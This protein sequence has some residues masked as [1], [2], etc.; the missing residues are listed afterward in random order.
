MCHQTMKTM[1]A[2][3]TRIAVRTSA[4]RQEMPRSYP[5]TS[6]MLSSLTAQMTYNGESANSL[7]DYH[8]SVEL[9]LG[10]H[11]PPFFPTPLCRIY[12]FP[13]LCRCPTSSIS[14]LFDSRCFRSPFYE[15]RP[16]VQMKRQLVNYSML[17]KLARKYSQT[18]LA[19]NESH[20]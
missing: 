17:T 8:S 5:P 16:L 13:C 6:N 11:Y 18:S 15:K 14:F 12:C 7:L 19:G 1:I 3:F 4:Q 2:R 9:F 20:I 10:L